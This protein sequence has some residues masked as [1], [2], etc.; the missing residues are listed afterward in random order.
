MKAL[1]ALAAVIIMV[2]WIW[3]VAFSVLWFGLNAVGPYN[4][5][6]STLAGFAW[7]LMF[8][9]STWSSTTRR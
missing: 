2:L 7:I 4:F 1:T 8:V 9:R 3:F 5:N 6:F